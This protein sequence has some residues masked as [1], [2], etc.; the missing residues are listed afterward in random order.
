MGDFRG[1]FGVDRYIAERSTPCALGQDSG[2]GALGKMA[3]TENDDAFWKRYALV[4]GGSD[5]P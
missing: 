4:N 5:M 2:F 3:H 1:Q